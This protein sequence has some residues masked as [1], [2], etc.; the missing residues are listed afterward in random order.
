M[1]NLMSSSLFSIDCYKPTHS[2]STTSVRH[3][4]HLLTKEK[5]KQ[6]TQLAFITLFGLG[7]LVYNPVLFCIGAL[8]GAAAPVKV[9]ETAQNI[10][11]IWQK[12]PIASALFI[13]SAA[14]FVAPAIGEAGAFLFAAYACSELVKASRKDNKDNKDNKEKPKE[15]RDEKY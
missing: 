7:L 1:E 11:S 15:T 4:K 13:G 12:W 6:A 8:I 3:E 2:F 10:L 14:F 5:I 9:S